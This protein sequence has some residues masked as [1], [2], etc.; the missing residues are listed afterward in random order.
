[1]LHETPGGAGNTSG[2]LRAGFYKSV[3]GEVIGV[4]GFLVELA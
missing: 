4:V 3:E 1:M 2:S